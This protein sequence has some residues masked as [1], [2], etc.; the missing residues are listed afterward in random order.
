MFKRSWK[1][2]GKLL[3]Q[4][5]TVIASRQLKDRILLRKQQKQEQSELPVLD[6]FLSYRKG[7]EKND[8]ERIKD[9]R[10]WRNGQKQEIQE[11][12]EMQESRE[13]EPKGAKTMVERINS[14]NSKAI[15][16]QL[17]PLDAGQASHKP[18][19]ESAEVANDDKKLEYTPAPPGAQSQE[20]FKKDEAGEK[21]LPGIEKYQCM[22]NDDKESVSYSLYGETVAFIVKTDSIEVVKTDESALLAAMQV[23]QQKWGS[24]KVDGNKEH[25]DICAELAE[26]YQI[27]LHF[28][29]EYLEAVEEEKQ[30]ERTQEEIRERIT[31]GKATVSDLKELR[32]QIVQNCP[33]KDDPLLKQSIGIMLSIEHERDDYPVTRHLG[34]KMLE[35]LEKSIEQKEVQQGETKKKPKSSLER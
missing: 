35:V 11:T 2:Q 34:K 18:L 20:N 6:T 25:L 5:R 22:K 33:S 31:S 9:L 3:N 13:A 16:L 10:N 28:P 4:E 8:P 29:E 27:K 23:A 19:P 24:V 17:S 12:R 1:G 32:A 26:K 7:L 15:N 14:E 21:E 30:K